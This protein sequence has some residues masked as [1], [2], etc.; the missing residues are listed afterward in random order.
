MEIKLNYDGTENE[1]V[2]ALGLSTEKAEKIKLHFKDVCLYFLKDATGMGSNKDK[3][4]DCYKKD[5]EKGAI[6]MDA[7]L[8][9]KDALEQFNPKG[10]NA[11]TAAITLVYSAAIHTLDGM[12]EKMEKDE[13]LMQLMALKK[14]LNRIDEDE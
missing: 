9:L 7:G 8:V 13:T 11:I 1:L 4:W 12:M 14:V 10:E 5:A 6:S 3:R 2:Q